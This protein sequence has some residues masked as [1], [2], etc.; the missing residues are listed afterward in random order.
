LLNLKSP[1][2]ENPETRPPVYR[3]R[4]ITLPH[5]L[6]FKRI[7]DHVQQ[8]ADDDQ[9]AFTAE[10]ILQIVYHAISTSGHYIT[11]CK[12]WCKKDVA[13]KTWTHFKTFFAAEYHDRKEE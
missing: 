2:K 5:F 10:K 13:D 1:S 12:E 6:F 4:P 7:D 9:V 8:Y 11:A 3:L